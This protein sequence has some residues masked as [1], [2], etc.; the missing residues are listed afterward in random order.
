MAG[1]EEILIQGGRVLDPGTAF[2]GHGDLLLRDGRIAALG[3]DLDAASARTID[4]RGAIVCPG[5]VDLHTHLRF[6]GFPEKETM[7]SGT[8]AAA[9]GGFTTVCAM[10][11]TSPVVDDVV[12]LEQIL[13]EAR[14][15]G[16]VHVRQLAAVT[17]GLAGKQLNDLSALAAAG[18]VAFSDDGK[19]VVQ[20]GVM[21]AALEASAT[22]RKV[23][24]VHE[25]D[26]G[27]V[28]D[29]VADSSV[30]GLLGLPEWPC[31][32]EATMVA[33]DLAL[34]QE[35]GGRLHIAHVSCAE[36]VGLVREAKARGLAVTAEATPH[37]LTLTGDVVAGKG[38]G[39]TR[40]HP[41]A[42]V[43]PPLRSRD[44]VAALVAA[45]ADGT[46]DAIATDHAPHSVADKQG[47]FVAA[48]FGFSAIET[49]LSLV[50]CLVRNGALDLMTAIARLTSG[51]AGCFGLDAGTLRIGAV[52]DVC[53]FDPNAEWKVT[54]EQ[55][56]SRGKNTP[57]LG[58]GLRGRVIHTIV[59]GQLVHSL[60][61][62]H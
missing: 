5:F 41:N 10:A 8:A 30:A 38:I 45:L 25:E 50:L 54:G 40:A 31:S 3:P 39:L 12:T 55:L 35:A 61:S 26:P 49:A 58:A 33:R 37:H 1:S 20:R 16:R 29:G 34:L 22:L 14:R 42:K 48:A 21:R 46:I 28:R 51:P 44:D 36:T 11:N 60:S 57:L 7:E 56:R 59:A 13:S 2:D 52:A 47:S 19:P 17:H 6:P 18:A 4:A 15:V 43:N 23:I 32:G 27:L 53:V 9:A 24:S 62:P